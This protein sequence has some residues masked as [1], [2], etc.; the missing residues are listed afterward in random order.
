MTNIVVSGR[1]FEEKSTS[2]CWLRVK[3]FAESRAYPATGPGYEQE[4]R[5][6]QRMLPHKFG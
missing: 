6:F 1:K 5:H 4:I 3:K 2:I